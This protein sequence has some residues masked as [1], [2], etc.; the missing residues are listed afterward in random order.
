MWSSYRFSAILSG[1]ISCWI[2]AH[3]PSVRAIGVCASGA[4]AM[5]RSWRT[6]QIV[7]AP[8]QTIAEGI[9]I[10]TPCAAAVANVTALA[11]DVMFVDDAALTATMRLAHRDIGVVLEPSGAAALAALMD[12]REQFRGRL[13]ATVLTGG[14]VSPGNLT[15]WFAL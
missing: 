1:G 9:S 7:T 15:E 13:V 5:E 6:G 10:E 11:D 2:K 12:H 8:A 3:A 14:N 4:P